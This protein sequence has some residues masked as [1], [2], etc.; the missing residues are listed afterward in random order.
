V[1]RRKRLEYGSIS[2]TA[3]AACR[4]LRSHSKNYVLPTPTRIQ[5]ESLRLNATSACL[6]LLSFPRLRWLDLAKARRCHGESFLEGWDTRCILLR[7][8]YISSPSPTRFEYSNPSKIAS[9]IHSFFAPLSSC[10]SDAL[11]NSHSKNS[12]SFDAAWRTTIR[13]DSS[14]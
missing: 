10:Q 14:G 5:R 13:F 3:A 7:I 12:R 11:R 2:K 1:T 4:L 9:S 6:S 8:M